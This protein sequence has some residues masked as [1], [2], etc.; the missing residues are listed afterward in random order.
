MNES[1]RVLYL[2]AALMKTKEPVSFD[3]H[4]YLETYSDLVEQG[5]DDEE[6]AYNHWK[7]KGAREG[8]WGS[9]SMNHPDLV[10]DLAGIVLHMDVF[11]LLI[12]NLANVKKG[13][14]ANRGF[15]K[16]V[17]NYC[18][19]LTPPPFMNEITKYNK[20]KSTS[21]AYLYS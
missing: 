2:G 4:F 16:L 11:D 18:Y 9:R 17:A 1:A 19:A 8:R 5:I 14:T 20:S 6:K 10:K 13:A 15:D 12:K 3:P 7:T 21:N